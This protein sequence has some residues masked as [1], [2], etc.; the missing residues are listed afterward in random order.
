MST[1]KLIGSAFGPSDTA[2]TLSKDSSATTAAQSTQ[3]TSDVSN[4]SGAQ[5]TQT[6][7]TVTGES[8]QKQPDTK[9]RASAQ[10]SSQ[11]TEASSTTKLIGS[12]FGSSSTASILSK[13]SSATTAAQST[14]Q[15]SDV[16]NKSGAQL[17]QTTTT[18]TGESR[19][20]QPDTKNRASAQSN[21]Q[22]TEASSTTKLIGSAFGPSGTTNAAETASKFNSQNQNGNNG[23]GNNANGGSDTGGDKKTGQGPVADT[24]NV[25]PSDALGS[26]PIASDPSKPHI[27]G[28]GKDFG[29]TGNSKSTRPTDQIG[30]PSAASST[31]AG[32]GTATSLI[33]SA[34]A[35]G[36]PTATI[37]GGPTPSGPIT[38][39]TAGGLKAIANA[40]SDPITRTRSIG[41]LVAVV[42]GFTLIVAMIVFL[43]W[44]FRRRGKQ[45]EDNDE[46][47]SPSGDGEK[48]EMDISAPINQP[49]QE[50]IAN[51]DP[52]AELMA[53]TNG[54]DYGPSQPSQL[55]NALVNRASRLSASGKSFLDIYGGANTPYP[56]D[57]VDG[58]GRPLTQQFLMPEANKFQNFQLNGLGPISP[59]NPN[60]PGLSSG[61]SHQRNISTLSKLSNL[62][63]DVNPDQPAPN[64]DQPLAENTEDPFGDENVAS[65]YPLAAA[66][67]GT[68]KSQNPPR[69]MGRKG[70][71]SWMTVNTV[72]TKAAPPITDG[73]GLTRKPSRTDYTSVY[74]RNPFIDPPEAAGAPPMPAMPAIPKHLQQQQQPL[75]KHQQTES[76]TLMF[77]PNTVQPPPRYGRQQ[78][79]RPLSG[80]GDTE[81]MYGGVLDDY[82]PRP[83]ST[84]VGVAPLKARS[85]GE[86]RAYTGG[87]RKSNPFDLEVDD[88]GEGE[89]REEGTVKSVQ[90]WLSGVAEAERSRMERENVI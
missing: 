41:I 30:D 46:G 73:N 24:S 79:A 51:Y 52:S 17:T 42:I 48:G 32:I 50:E 1:T 9:N 36:K 83:P 15:T 11:S 61:P 59:F 35:S 80:P 20:K 40:F 82:P 85:Y 12:A 19:Q 70:T 90:S 14:Q 71:D 34:V 26:A 86:S 64:A 58:N 72:A 37:N 77:S 2:S 29:G 87:V 21:S 74:M 18:A 8:R 53:D 45:R 28:L 6:T 39:E 31:V 23:N 56:Q 63:S 55:D 33:T 76:V 62:P 43:W 84:Q 65:L 27:S 66:K 88:G 16:S 5:S 44:F 78:Q 13:D 81:V 7:T 47:M 49:T 3:Q 67:M 68:M 89:F 54:L 22:S 4:K 38:K 69:N 10:S 57:V 75:S 60:V 25:S